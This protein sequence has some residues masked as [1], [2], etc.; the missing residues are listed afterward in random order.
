MASIK[1]V[2]DNGQIRRVRLDPPGIAALLEV[3]GSLLPG[4]VD[5]HYI[6]DEGDRCTVSNDDEIAEAIRLHAS[7]GTVAKFACVSKAGAP[8]A[9]AAA[10]A[11]AG[12]VVLTLNGKKVSIEGPDP[13]LSL[14][15][16]L[17]GAGLL[18]PA[19]RGGGP[20]A[21]PRPGAIPTR[22]PCVSHHRM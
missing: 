15:D 21:R 4:D 6:D 8:A 18:T 19:G 10:S 11:G 9:S 7:Q 13:R 1:L 2:R 22:R 20:N 14:L 16:Y 17:C 12:A 5:I 3:A